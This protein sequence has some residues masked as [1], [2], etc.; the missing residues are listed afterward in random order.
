MGGSYISNLI[1]SSS[2]SLVWGLIN[3]L[4]LLTHLPFV[5]TVWPENATAYYLALYEIANFDL[6]PKDKIEEAMSESVGRSE[7]DEEKYAKATEFLN[8]RAIE[9]GYENSDVFEKSVF[10]Y[11]LIGSGLLIGLLILVLGLCCWKNPRVKSCLK[12]LY[13][14]IFFNFF[15]RTALETILET[16]VI[17]MIKIHDLSSRSSYDTLN[18]VLALTFLSFL[19]IFV[20]ILPIFLTCKRD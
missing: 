4:Q 7:E 13:N 17:Y 3:S 6:I 12:N 5:N 16:A 2:L 19:T 15:I 10:N 20:I 1:L 14:A 9:A 8:D 11:I 18:T